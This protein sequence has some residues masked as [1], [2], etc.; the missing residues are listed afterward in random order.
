MSAITQCRA[1]P[2]HGALKLIAVAV[3]E[4]V[5]SCIYVALTLSMYYILFR[6]IPQHRYRCTCGL[7]QHRS[8]DDRSQGNPGDFPPGS[9]IA[10]LLGLAA[11][12]A[13]LGR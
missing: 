10:A 7:Q 13:G 11:F 2:S 5:Y 6:P 9:G 12:F 3:F 4:S 8:A 1:Q